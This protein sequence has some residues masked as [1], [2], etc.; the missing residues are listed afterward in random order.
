[1]GYNGGVIKRKML[2]LS[3]LPLVLI[4]VLIGCGGDNNPESAPEDGNGT[5]KA[6]IKD[7]KNFL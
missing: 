5:G 1:M 6:I 3:L 4:G 2:N 7:P